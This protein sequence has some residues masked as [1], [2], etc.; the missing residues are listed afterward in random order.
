MGDVAS[1]NILGVLAITTG[2]VFTFFGRRLNRII[3]FLAGFYALAIV[4]FIVTS[5][6][7][8]VNALGGSE[9]GSNRELIYLGICFGAGLVG[10]IVML[11]FIPLGLFAMGALGGFALAMFCLTWASETAIAND[12][13]RIA[14]IAVLT[15]LV[16]CLAVALQTHLLVI[17]TAIGGAY[18]VLF[19]IDIFCQ[20]LFGEATRLVLSG[21]VQD[22]QI[23]DDRVYG[24][25]IGMAVLAVAGIIVQYQF[26]SPNYTAD[27]RRKKQKSLAYA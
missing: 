10:G 4:A 12:A 5:H 24:M 3:F 25:L 8:P 27:A 7:E 9:W 22:Y 26:T 13:G 20:T 15:L 2:F 19:G 23:K 11:L 17:A 14:F 18:G 6:A 16:A 1:R 21:N